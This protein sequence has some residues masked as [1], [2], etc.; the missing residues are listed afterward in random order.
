[1]ARRAEA[2]SSR[3]GLHDEPRILGYVMSR[4][5]WPTARPAV[6]HALSNHVDHVLVLDHAS[7][8]ETQARLE[9]PRSSGRDACRSIDSM[10]LPSSRKLSTTV[11]ARVGE[12]RCP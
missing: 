12:L 5:E 10:T 1:M 2:S 4:D 8:D 9:A 11:M 3:H 7:S 6:T